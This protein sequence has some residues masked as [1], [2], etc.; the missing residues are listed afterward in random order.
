MGDIVEIAYR[1]A[2]SG[3]GNCMRAH[4][5]AFALNSLQAFFGTGGLLVHLD[6][7][8]KIVP[9]VRRLVVATR[10]CLP[11]LRTALGKRP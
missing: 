4:R 10:A 9:F 8:G 11:M 5:A 1:I 2:V 7:L 3:F 6:D